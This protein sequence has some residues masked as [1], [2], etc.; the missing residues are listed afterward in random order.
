[1]D[2]TLA[3]TVVGSGAGVAGVGVA[4][5]AAVGQARSG[6]STDAKVTAELGYGQLSQDGVLCVEFASGKT[7]VIAVPKP[8]EARASAG[9]D[10][11]KKTRREPEVRPV[12]VIFIRNA[13]PAR[14][15]RGDVATAGAG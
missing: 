15:C 3:W 2:A 11:G 4:V 10:P 13:G 6:R 7:D 14:P 8:G 5:V 1:V 12:N 9:R